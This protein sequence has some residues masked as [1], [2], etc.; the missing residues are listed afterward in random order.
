[1]KNQQE[2]GKL[3]LHRCGLGRFELNAAETA[4]GF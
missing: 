1:M 3:D 2:L 4:K